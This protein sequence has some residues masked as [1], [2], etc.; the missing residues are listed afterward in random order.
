MVDDCQLTPRGSRID[1]EVS[2]INGV[3]C[4]SLLFHDLTLCALAV[5]SGSFVSLEIAV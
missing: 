1:N 5:I 4:V 2:K 3:I